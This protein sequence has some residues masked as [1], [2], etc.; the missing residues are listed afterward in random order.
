MVE[1]MIASG[2]L[3]DMTFKN[4]EDARD[5]SLG[6]DELNLKK[7]ESLALKKES[8]VEKVREGRA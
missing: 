6:M 1:E 3:G 2:E 7:V 5:V 8:A 4:L